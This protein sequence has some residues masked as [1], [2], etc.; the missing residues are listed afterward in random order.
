MK[1]VEIRNVSKIFKVYG[2]KFYALKNVSLDVNQGEILAL[3]G[4][5]GSGKT[6]LINIILG[7]L[8]PE[9]GRIKIFGK[10]IEDEDFHKNVNLASGEEKFHWMMT[11]EDVLNFF[12][13]VYGLD[14]STRKQRIKE[15]V[16]LLGL[17]NIMKRRFE[18]LSTGE[19]MRLALAK[20]LLNKPKLLLLDEPTLGLDPEIATKIRN[21]IKKLNKIYRVTIL[22]TSHYMHEVEQLADRFAFINKGK[23]VEVGEISQL[24]RKRQNLEEY[25]VKQIEEK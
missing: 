19:R 3:I 8:L 6:T 10:S 13:L 18:W 14:T 5:N 11:V 24:K 2:R 7:L 21:E 4:P 16:S 22:L 20:A 12:G 15:L 17:S 23:I 9:K 25:F 1:A